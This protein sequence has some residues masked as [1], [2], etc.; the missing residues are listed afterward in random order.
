M[1]PGSRLLVRLSSLTARRRSPLRLACA[2]LILL[3]YASIVPAGGAG[4]DR[5]RFSSATA[6]AVAG[7]TLQVRQGRLVVAAVLPG[8]PAASAGLLAGDALLVVNDF[9]LID[10]DPLSPEAALSLFEKGGPAEARLIVGRGAGTLGIYLPLRPPDSLSGLPASPEPLRIGGEAPLFTARD[11]KGEEVSLKAFRGRAVLIDFWASW[12]PPCRDA[13]IPLLRLAGQYE[14]RLVII[15]VG[16]D[17]DSRAF[18]AFAYNHHLPGHQIL[19]GGGD[20]PISRRYGV[21]SAGIP[22][23]VLIDAQGRVASMGPSLQEQEAVIARLA[24]SRK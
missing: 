2:A 3:W 16:L 8:S 11:L 10:L 20:G 13:V 21:P 5:P 17:A 23:S 4:P 12:C 14:D 24:A 6:T 7:M 15:G 1:V 9:N 22:Y 18:E 19:D